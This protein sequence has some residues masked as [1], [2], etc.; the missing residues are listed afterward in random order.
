MGSECYEKKKSLKHWF[1]D[2]VLKTIYSLQ[3][4]TFK[5]RNWKYWYSIQNIFGSFC[6]YKSTFVVFY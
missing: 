1:W 3:S 4:K 2:G 6:N 5:T